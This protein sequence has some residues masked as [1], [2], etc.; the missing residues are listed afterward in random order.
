[1]FPPNSRIRARTNGY[2]PAAARDSTIARA[3]PMAGRTLG[4]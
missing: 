3:V 2:R 4:C 1:M